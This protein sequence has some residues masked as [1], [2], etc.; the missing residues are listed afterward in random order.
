[1]EA[2]LPESHQFISYVPNINTQQSIEEILSLPL[3]YQSMFK[4]R[5]TAGEWQDWN[6]DKLNEFVIQADKIDRLYHVVATDS[7]WY[8]RI[9]EIS[10]RMEYD[11]VKY[12]VEMNANC[13]YLGFNY[14]G[15]GL[16]SITKLPDF[17][18]RNM[19]S[20]DQNPYQIYK[21][22]LEDGYNVQEIDP[23]LKMHPKFWNVVP[24]LKYHCHDTIYKN[25]NVLTQY[26][27]Q[28]PPILANSVEEYIQE[29]NWKDEHTMILY[30]YSL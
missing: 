9:W 15:R 26:K 14:S 25:R 11:G 24:M 27:D 6:K 16:I 3:E 10:C 12:F 13:D 28:L 30:P 2:I 8:H 17:F 4:K 5:T 19:L 21:S 18:L 29:K 23:L 22:L 7:V 1:M 20:K